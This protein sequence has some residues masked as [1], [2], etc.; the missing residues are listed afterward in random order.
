MVNN[1][2]AQSFCFRPRKKEGPHPAPW[3][4]RGAGNP[5]GQKFDQVM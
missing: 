2:D 5:F 3:R 1:R 4:K